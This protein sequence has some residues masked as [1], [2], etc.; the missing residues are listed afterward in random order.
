M[1]KRIIALS[2][3]I[4]VA[5]LSR[6]FPHAPNFTPIA[7]IALFGGAY[8]TNRWSG[9]LIPL[10]A[11]LISDA[12]MGFNG[13]AFAEQVIAVYGSF[14]LIS[15]IGSLLQRNKSML[16]I[17]AASVAGSVL[18][19]VITNLAVWF[20]GFFHQPALYSLTPSGLLECY[21]AA[22]PF[23]QNTV[24]GDFCYNAILF[25]G[26][27]LASINIPSLQKQA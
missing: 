12:L 11:L 5:A 21:V 15:L 7:A 9:F 10:A 20:G 26:F 16:N 8:F 3:I 18:F 19:F 13:W 17:G 27:Y 14:T 24:A 23:F 6:L 22:L 4:L 2:A 25:G 1:N